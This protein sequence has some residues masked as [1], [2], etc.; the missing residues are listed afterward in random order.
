MRA[1]K[2]LWKPA[3][4]CVTCYIDLWHSSCLKPNSNHMCQKIDSF[5]CTGFGPY[6]PSRRQ[7]FA[8]WRERL[9]E[10][11]WRRLHPAEA[12]A[13]DEAQA[14]VWRAI[15]PALTKAAATMFTPA[16]AVR[17]AFRTGHLGMD[18]AAGVDWFVSMPVVPQPWYRR[19]YWRA[20]NRIWRVIEAL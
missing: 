6:T 17:E 13:Q 14:A 5:V 19:A 2:A 20:L 15:T 12:R 18:L 16:P 10:R 8:R 11:V 1:R 3:L 4:R 9:R 7:R